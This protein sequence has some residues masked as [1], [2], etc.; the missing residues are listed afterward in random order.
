[1]VKLITSMDNMNILKIES[2]FKNQIEN[3]KLQEL[4]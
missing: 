4:K 2:N 1:M 3:L